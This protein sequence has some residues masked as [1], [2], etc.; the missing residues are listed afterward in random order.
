M[1]SVL[2]T[3]IY[4]PLKLTHAITG[5]VIAGLAWVSTGGD[6]AVAKT[7]FNTA[8]GGDYIIAPDQVRGERKIRFQGDPY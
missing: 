1:G 3:L 7:I 8:V 2:A 5:S 6:N 4:A